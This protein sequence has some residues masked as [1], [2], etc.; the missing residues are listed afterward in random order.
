MADMRIETPRDL[1]AAA[2]ALNDALRSMHSPQLQLH[3]LISFFD[4]TVHL[5][6]QWRKVYL[7]PHRHTLLRLLL[8]PYTQG[9]QPQLWS[10]AWQYLRIMRE[11]EGEQLDLQQAVSELLC[12]GILAHAY[13]ADLRN[14]HVFLRQ[15]G[16]AVRDLDEREWRRVYGSGPAPY[17]LFDAYCAG[18]QELLDTHHPLHAAQQRWSTWLS[19]RD[20]VSV[21]LL[22]EHENEQVAGAVLRMEIASRRRSGGVH[23]NNVLGADADL[24]RRQLLGAGALAAAFAQR[25]LGYRFEGQELYFQIIDLHAAFSGGSLGLAATV[26]LACHLSGQVNAR[27]RWTLPADTACVASLDPSG[28]LESVSWETIRRKIRLAFFSPLRRIVIPVEHVEEA[29]RHVQELQREH[30]SRSFEVYSAL[31][32]EDC[33]RPGHVVETTARNPYD[34]VQ[35]FARRH[36]RSAV[37]L[38]A[39]LFLLAAAALFYRTFFVF[40]DLEETMGIAVAA[41]AIVYNPHDS[42]EW[43]FRDG[44]LVM[45]AETSFGDIEVGDGFSR[46]LVLYNMSPGTK[47]IFL[48]IEGR[49]AGQWYMNSGGG[50]RMLESTVPTEISVMYAPTAP[51]LRHDAALV[52]RES[53]GG[54]EYFRLALNG[55][56]GRAMAGGYALRLGSGPAYMTWGK[57]G[58]A[59]THG[60]LTIESW[61]RSLGWN[62]CFLHNGYNTPMNLES[63][64][65]TISFTDGKPQIALGAQRFDVPLATPMKPNKWHHIALAY[66]VHRPAIRFFLDGE[67]VLERSRPVDLQ[68]RMTPFVSLGAYADSLSVSSFLDCE[69]DNFRVWWR[70][71]DEKDI[72]RTK[73]VMLAGTVPDLKAN[74][75]MESNCDI[76]TFN[77]SGESPDAELR[78]RPTIVRSTA[79]L[80]PGTSIPRLTAGPR[81]VP[82]LLLPAGTYLHFARQ[83]LL[84]RSDATFSFW[85][86][87]GPQ[88][89][90]AM[91]VRNL[92]HFVSFT[93]DTIAMSYSG[94]RS[95]II[96]AIPVGWHHVAVRVLADGRK[97]IFIDGEQRAALEP[98]L[99]PGTDYHDWHHRYDGISFGVFDDRY[100]MFSAKMHGTM[101][102]SLAQNRRVAEIAIWRRLLGNEE[103][104]I[105]AAGADP[106][107]DHLAAYWRFDH[108]PTADLNFIDKVDGQ[109]LHIKS[110]PAF[111]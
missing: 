82:A 35:S 32:F 20:A 97:E 71:F 106:P 40:P 9:H 54:T 2:K 21:V 17:A 51:S 12:K 22:E 57:N 102:E 44:T 85:W 83:L 45:P 3:A 5:P 94:C 68:D 75:D 98:C 90:T 86:Q 34:R 107:P 61:V 95:D 1:D 79:P 78:Y 65:L 89:S 88:R 70:M 23:I 50:A 6:L 11:D 76:T 99:T 110:A 81:R 37:L 18:Q 100:Q 69:V 24:T 111:R 25:Q 101:R 7:L 93:S 31:S 87:T 80:Q 13:V 64:N 104:A 36:A 28:A 109:L 60:E 47:E 74:F 108:A 63:G 84:P 27:A 96:G 58:L 8:H 103:I 14:L 43:A 33:F 66:S 92:G 91:V 105:L 39:A 62:G 52:L 53:Q 30:P 26:G 72:K 55:A 59:F 73:D 15:A 46:T 49:D 77:G 67:M 10:S 29:M 19:H 16:V 42:L 4:R 48:S 41:S 38:F 56:A